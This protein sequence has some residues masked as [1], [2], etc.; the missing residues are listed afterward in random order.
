MTTRPTICTL[1]QLAG[2]WAGEQ[3]LR[4]SDLTRIVLSIIAL[5]IGLSSASAQ[6][7]R[8]ASWPEVVAMIPCDHV[9]KDD[10]GVLFILGPVDVEQRRFD[11]RA[12]TDPFEVKEIQQRCPFRRR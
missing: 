7:I 11:I 8:F 3:I 4:L 5:T 1:W 2:S 12:V 9:W 6:D 10:T